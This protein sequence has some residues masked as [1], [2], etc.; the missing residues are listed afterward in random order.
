MCFSVFLFTLTPVCQLT[1]E[2]YPSSVKALG[3]AKSILES[4][5]EDFQMPS[6]ALVFDSITDS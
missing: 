5:Q 4:K 2:G 6:R 3:L 1:S